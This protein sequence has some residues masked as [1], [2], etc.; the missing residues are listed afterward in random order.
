MVY[1]V[2]LSKDKLEGVKDKKK[3]PKK[4]GAKGHNQKDKE[5]MV[6]HQG[7]CKYSIV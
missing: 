7:K 6:P 3:D 2:T 1:I 5:D 4:K